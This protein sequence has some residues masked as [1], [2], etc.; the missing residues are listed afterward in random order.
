[1][2]KRQ[3]SD[4]TQ[5]LHS[6]ETIK[7]YKDKVQP[8]RD[9]NGKLHTEMPFQLKNG[10]T[11]RLVFANGTFDP[12][13]PTRVITHGWIGGFNEKEEGNWLN[14]MMKA[15]YGKFDGNI[16]I[17]DWQETA[18]NIW[19]SSAAKDTKLV[20]KSAAKLLSSL[21]LN[22]KQT[23]LIGHSLGGQVAGHIGEYFKKEE[24]PIKHIIALDPARPAFEY[25]GLPFLNPFS[26]PVSNTDR[27]EETD[28]S[29]VTVI[30]SD[31]EGPFSL[32][33]E[34]NSG[35]LDIYLT[36]E[37]LD[38]YSDNDDSIWT[39]NH[40]SANQFAIEM[41]KYGLLDKIVDINSDLYQK[42]TSDPK[43]TSFNLDFTG[44]RLKVEKRE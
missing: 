10:Q 7:L 21:G 39:L 5:K 6:T 31:Y 9:Y 20:G 18:G 42:A 23:T 30:H 33:Y 24:V 14:G 26:E 35:H 29:K 19:Y 36:D 37:T 1:M 3:E 2:Y 8:I 22:P 43:V 34:K 27:L 13:K 25:A 15:S 41:V 38:Y 32:G 44:N 16:I 12:N 4:L 28:A 11:A 40:S 17:I